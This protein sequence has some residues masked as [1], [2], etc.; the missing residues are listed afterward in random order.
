MSREQKVLVVVAHPDDEVLGCGGT[1]ARLVREGCSVSIAILGEGITSR[2][3]QREQ[4]DPEDIKDLHECSLR[5]AKVLGVEDVHTFDLPDNRFDSVPLL[6]VIKTVE[7]L[8]ETV[9][10]DTVYTH[11][12]G[13]LN[14][15]H[16]IVGRAVLTATRPVKACSVRAVYAFEVASSSEWLFGTHEKAFM[17]DTFVDIAE[18]LEAKIEALQ[19]YSREMRDFPHP[20]SEQAVRALA[21][22]RGASVGCVAAEALV[23]IRRSW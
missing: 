12:G 9:R 16:V 7:N 10:P 19:L 2:C 15:D 13:D 17:P 21:T 23:T 5:A 18:T 3:A 8:I 4:A 14:I 6:D 11:H 1:I 20:R 22:W